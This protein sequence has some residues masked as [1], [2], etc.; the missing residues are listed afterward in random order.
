MAKRSSRITAERLR[1]ARWSRVNPIR[2]LTPE[3]LAPQ[4]DEF[5][6]GR[7]G[8]AARLWEAIVR[9]DLI[10]GACHD[11][12]AAAVARCPWEIITTE[13][14]P[15]AAQ[16]AAALRWVYNNLRAEDALD[17]VVRGGMSLLIRQMMGAVAYQY[18][19]H[20][21][22]LQPVRADGIQLPL[23]KT[24]ATF[25]PDTLVR[26]KLRACPLWWFEAQDG[27]FRYLPE[28]WSPAGVEMR[29][30]E[31]M[32]IRG[33]GLMEATSVAYVLRSLAV[34]DW[35]T[36]CEK[37]SVPPV[38]GKTGAAQ[39]SEGWD[40]MVAAVEAYANDFGAVI[41]L[42][43]SLETPTLG[44][45]GGSPCE[46]FVDVINRWIAIRWRGGDL[47][48]LSSTAGQGT[49][50]S[51]QAANTTAF[52]E[53]DCLWVSEQINE[54]ID[55][56]VIRYLFGET[57][58]AYL[59]VVPP[60]KADGQ[61]VRD[62]AGFLADRGVP[63]GATQLR[64]RLNIPAPEPDEPL[65][66]AARTP[67]A[68]G[69]P[70]D[71]AADPLAN[72]QPADPA[73]PALAA[74][75]RDLA[76]L[77]VQLARLDTLVRDAAADPAEITRRAEQLLADLEAFEARLKVAPQDAASATSLALAGIYA[78]AMALG[79]TQKP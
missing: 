62:S 70:V 32:V 27:P 49:G 36:F 25:A 50:A 75:A 28:E 65:L 37:F 48:T 22:L 57:P 1:Q 7:Y 78:E 35:S 30:G 3:T 44:G 63:V 41:N 34:T 23:P 2:G 21:I 11:N 29:E 46:K 55:A 10:I 61:A 5:A 31:W 12:R 74:M 17:T 76:P 77:R 6:A 47:N 26:L 79:L 13:P 43:D 64:A 8:R 58:L 39:G 15:R 45:N 38:L 51:V 67:A 19:V 56:L 54:H 52:L 68:P 69:L 66:Q 42:A 4:L 59:R 24:E 73:A 14:T 9:R 40:A 60:Q 71:P 53:D 20:E 18:Q 72:E 16:H 33:A